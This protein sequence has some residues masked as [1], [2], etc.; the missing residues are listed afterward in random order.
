MTVLR[1]KC[2]GVYAIGVRSDEQV[3]MKIRQLDLMNL[4]PCC[5]DE[6]EFICIESYRRHSAAHVLR[7]ML[8]KS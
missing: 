4:A 1:R 2:D 5:S 7:S 3:A 6:D 8:I